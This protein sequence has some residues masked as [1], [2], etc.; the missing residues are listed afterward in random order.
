MKYCRM[1]GTELKNEAKFCAKCGTAVID[2][3]QPEIAAAKAIE[4]SIGIETKIEDTVQ[5]EMFQQTEVVQEHET[6]QE[7]VRPVVP[8]LAN[9]VFLGILFLV[10][11]TVMFLLPSI[12][13]MNMSMAA[14]YGSF[15]LAAA[16]IVSSV[17]T[18]LETL[19]FQAPALIAIVTGIALLQKRRGAFKLAMLGGIFQLLTAVGSLLI[20]VLVLAFAPSLVQIYVWDAETVELGTQLMRSQGMSRFVMVEL[21][22]LLMGV[23]AFVF[24]LI[25][26]G[27]ERKTR[28]QVALDLF[29]KMP[30]SAVSLITLIPFISLLMMLKGT[31]GTLIT[32]SYIGAAAIAAQSMVG[33]VVSTYTIPAIYLII[34]ALV[35][36]MLGYKW[37]YWKVSVP[38]MSVLIVYGIIMIFVVLSKGSEMLMSIG[39]PAEL[40]SM[41]NSALMPQM[42]AQ[43]LLPLALFSWI[44]ASARGSIPAWLQAIL[45]SVIVILYIVMDA[46]F[47]FGW[48]AVAQMGMP[49]PAA[50]YAISLIVLLFAV[51]LGIACKP[52]KG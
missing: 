8:L 39:T 51:P 6:W 50:Q 29:D 32:G 14:A 31:L 28:S 16:T 23:A 34:G 9:P 27:K 52:K 7:P 20:T 36:G 25:A 42:L 37:K 30:R 11:G 40:M 13:V 15:Y 48:T 5:S 44:A 2:P 49:I 41:A 43:V 12:P 4:E 21:P 19:M 33:T 18:S 47:S 38:G 35:Y 22:V 1:C 10:S 24:T 3:A 45:G 17:L 26:R 46:L